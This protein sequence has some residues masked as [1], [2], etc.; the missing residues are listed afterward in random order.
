VHGHCLLHSRALSAYACV[1][2]AAMDGMLMA[3]G[4]V[5]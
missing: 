2:C 5:S 4:G 1:V 3:V